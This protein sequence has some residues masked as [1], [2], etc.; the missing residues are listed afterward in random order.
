MAELDCT[1]R[2]FPPGCTRELVVPISSCGYE[3]RVQLRRGDPEVPGLRSLAP[4]VRM[5]LCRL[6]D[7]PHRCGTP[8]WPARRDTSPNNDKC[9]PID[10]QTVRRTRCGG[11]HRGATQIPVDD[12]SGAIRRPLP[13]TLRI[14]FGRIRSDQ[15]PARC[16]VRRSCRSALGSFR[17]MIWTVLPLRSYLVVMAS[18]EATVEASQMCD[19]ERSMT[20]C[21]GSLT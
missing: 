16:P 9:T 15:W 2:T 5:S 7:T 4:T 21:S 20:I 14:K 12:S 10:A 19:W 1:E 17:P 8:W 11:T 6:A 13:D 3:D 18:R